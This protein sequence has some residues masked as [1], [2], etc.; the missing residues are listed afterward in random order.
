VSAIEELL[1]GKS[2]GSR[3]EN[4]D[5]GRRGSAALTTR[6]PSI[7]KR[8]VL[9]SSTSGGRTVGIVRSLTQATEFVFYL[10]FYIFFSL[11]APQLTPRFK[12]PVSLRICFISLYYAMKCSRYATN[13]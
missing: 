7:R 8:L 9:T 4:R 13:V 11:L 5:Y 2:S 12:G 1:R 3:L 6:H 10:L